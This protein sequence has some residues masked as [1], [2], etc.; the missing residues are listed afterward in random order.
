[1][2]KLCYTGSMKKVRV[3]IIDPTVYTKEF[4]KSC[5]LNE[6]VFTVLGHDTNTNH[7]ECKGTDVTWYLS[8][9]SDGRRLTI[10]D[11]HILPPELFEL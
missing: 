1:M 4:I 6:Y 11:E 2:R 3:E 8:P 5:E 9:T 10:Y 7:I